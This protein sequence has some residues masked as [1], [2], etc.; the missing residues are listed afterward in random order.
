[1][2]YFKKKTLGHTVIM[3]RKNYISGDRKERALLQRDLNLKATDLGEY[4]EFRNIT[5]E[6]LIRGFQKYHAGRFNSGFGNGLGM[7]FLDR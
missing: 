3:G 2:N 6:P 5:T 1:M 4:K 7:P